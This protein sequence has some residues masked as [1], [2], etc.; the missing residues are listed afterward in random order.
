MLHFVFCLLETNE[1]MNISEQM[2]YQVNVKSNFKKT[3]TM[4]F[5]EK[6]REIRLRVE[7]YK[8]YPFVCAY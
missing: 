3:S 5:I 2:N 8:Y 4:I 7:F 1:G 6:K